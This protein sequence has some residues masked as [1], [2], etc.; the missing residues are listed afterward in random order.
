MPIV[1]LAQARWIDGHRRDAC[2]LPGRN[3]VS[4]YYCYLVRPRK[5]APKK[6]RKIISHLH[7][8]TST[9]PPPRPHRR[10]NFPGPARDSPTELYRTA[11]TNHRI[12]YAS[13]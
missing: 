2:N 8:P 9:T 5:I 11:P 13:Q 6:S 7:D 3:Q 12:A 10:D 1:T 4:T